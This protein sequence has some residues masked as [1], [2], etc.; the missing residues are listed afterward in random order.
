MKTATTLIASVACAL[1]LWAPSASAALPSTPAGWP[2]ELQ[3]GMSS[4]PGDAG[5]MRATT[6]FGFRYQYLAG[7]VNTG[8]GWATWNPNG[9]FVTRYVRES[10]EHGIAPVFTYYMIRRSA[11]GDR[12]EEADGVLG[13]LRNRDTMRAYYEDLRLFFE[14]AGA[15]GGETVVLHVEPDMWGYAQQ[16]S[17]GDDAASIPVEVAS[18]GLSDLAGLPDDLTGF[19]RA[20]VRLRDRYAR[21]V[22]LGYHVSVWGTSV[23]VALSD[24]PDAE[25]DRLGDRAAAFYRSLRVGFDI[26][27][28]E[29]SDRD[30]AFKEHVYGDGGAS[31][32]N[33][34]DFRRNV[35][36]LTR[37]V[38]GADQRVVMWQIPLG[39]TRMRAM[40]NT[41]RHYQDNRVEWLLD[42][43]GRGHLGAYRDAGVVA[44][45]FGGGA[46]GTTC[47]CDAAGDG[48]T[49]PP[50]I[51]GN[52]RPSFSADDDGGFFRDRARAYYAGGPLGLPASQSA[53]A[54]GQ[55]GTGA[56]PRPGRARGFRFRRQAK[57]RRV[58]RGNRVRLHARVRSPR[59]MRA[60]VELAITGPD[61][62]RFLRR[63]LDRQL[64]SPTRTRGYTLRWRVPKDAALGRYTFRISVF[65]SGG[66]RLLRRAPSVPLQ[67]VRR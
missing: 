19:A 55:T 16:R 31:W 4:Q 59:R 35:R 50:P 67:V 25:V 17:R 9:E 57:P 30:S 65:T 63:R 28:A 21:N 15:F 43:P 56:S 49:D 66:R 3:L 18:T 34:E 27:F 8:Q 26:S 5:G 53:P 42:D 12:Q 2:A 60:L 41:W 7:G 38:E 54:S 32:W 20:V 51:N 39:N 33:A 44:F 46:D 45:L 22:V 13:N 64:L 1:A 24:P 62:S 58:R 52:D 29:F 6:S 10:R 61:G 40:N 14:R 48:V 47:A 23:D 36:F 11:P 37:F